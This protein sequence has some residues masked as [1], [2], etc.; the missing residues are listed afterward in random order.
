[1][2]TNAN[3]T[4]IVIIGTMLMPFIYLALIWNQLP[5]QIIS[6]Y[7]SAGEPDGRMPKQ[8]VTLL[9]GILSL[10]IYLLFRFLPR[11]DP[12]GRL[13]S[14]AHYDKLRFIMTL[15]LAVITGWVYYM[16]DHQA[17]GRQMQSVLLAILGVMV[18]GMG[19]YLTTVKPNWLVGIR[20]PWTLENETVWRKTHRLGGRLMVAGGLLS[21]VLALVIPMPYTIGVFTAIILIS[22]FIPVVY[23]YVY[24]RQEKAHQLN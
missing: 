2:K 5:D 13:Q 18:A 4:E 16:A 24:F 6:H 22:S 23:S 12:K 10:G 21:A 9:M 8:A 1:M 17:S 3:S 20:T 11:L 19:N 7:N 14:S 15:T